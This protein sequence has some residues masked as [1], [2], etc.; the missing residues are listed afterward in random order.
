MNFDK[1]YPHV[2][3]NLEDR[4]KILLSIV[5]F[6]HLYFGLKLGLNHVTEIFENLT[7]F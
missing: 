6:Q 4:V 5:S 1:Q 2:I 7:N 3:K